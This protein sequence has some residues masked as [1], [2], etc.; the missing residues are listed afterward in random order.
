M[1]GMKLETGTGSEEVSSSTDAAAK[2]MDDQT[3]TT[4]HN[5][6]RMEVHFRARAEAECHD[7][8]VRFGSKADLMEF[9]ITHLQTCSAAILEKCLASQDRT[10]ADEWSWDDIK[11]VAMQGQ[12]LAAKTNAG[13]QANTISTLCGDIWDRWRENVFPLLKPAE[14]SDD[15]Q[16]NLALAIIACLTEDV[17][18]AIQD[19]QKNTNS[20]I[21]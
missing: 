18:P 2:S 9:L 7:G 1:D 3:A 13:N 8:I 19:L 6:E 20:I 17:K 16:M 11:T 12:D 14:C 15:S 4:I 10:V 21:R 5:W